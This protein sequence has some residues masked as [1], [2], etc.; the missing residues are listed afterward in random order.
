MTSE[1]LPKM[2][3]LRR[4][5]I[6]PEILVSLLQNGKISENIHGIPKG[7]QWRG[8]YVD[9]DT[10]YITLLVEHESF[11]PVYENAEVPAR[12]FVMKTYEGADIE[13]FKRFTKNAEHSK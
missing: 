7:A 11:D 3:R 13:V 6:Y 1:I 8:L 10:W 9:Q 12:T 5:N 2:R 4:Y